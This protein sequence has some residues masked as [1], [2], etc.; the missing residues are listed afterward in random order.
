MSDDSTKSSVLKVH[1]IFL[2]LLCHTSVAFIQKN[3]LSGKVLGHVQYSSLV[4][5]YYL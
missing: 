4:P 2:F 5:Y 3:K 1:I